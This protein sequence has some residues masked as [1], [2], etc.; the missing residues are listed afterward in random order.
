MDDVLL[1]APRPPTRFLSELRKLPAF[2]RRDVLVT[3]SYRMSFV[4][5]I[6]S[7][8]VQVLVFYFIGRMV[9][10]DKLPKFGGTQ[11]TYLEFAAIGIALGAFVYVG[12]ERVSAA[13]RNEQLMGTL[14]SLLMTPTSTATIQFGCVVWD[15]IYVPL[16]TGVFLAA[17]AFIFGMHVESS[18]V[19]PALAL[20]FAFIPF[21]WGLGIASAAAVL[22]FRRGS[23][24]IG[25]GL[26]GLALVSGMYF[27]IDLLP[28][29]LSQISQFNPLAL[30]VD[31]MRQA[32]LGG[33][34]WGEVAP[35]LALLAPMAVAT[36]LVGF[37]GFRLAVRRERDRGTLGLY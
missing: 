25:L 10:P 13:I 1:Q 31:G 26:V 7:L 4:T 21:V 34:G 14:E 17:I 3:L 28:H 33:D 35:K 24:M 23:G 20:L 9:D 37:V 11:V 27:P 16:R 12:L 36:L 8:G 19:L 2:V 18:G 22:T 30:G 5:D 32:L 6:A 29:W 15:L